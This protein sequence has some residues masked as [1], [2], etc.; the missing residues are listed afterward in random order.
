MQLLTHHIEA[1]GQ[2][3]MKLVQTAEVNGIGIGEQPRPRDNYKIKAAAG[4]PRPID[5]KLIKWGIVHFCVFF[6]LAT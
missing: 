1:T 2:I 5:N 4:R 6:M 3:H